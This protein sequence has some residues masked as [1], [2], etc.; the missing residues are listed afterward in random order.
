MADV[1][2]SY[3]RSDRPRCTLIR[4]ALAAL[5]IDVWFDAGI[6]PGHVF[7][8]EIEHQIAESKAVLVL[9]S[10]TSAAS[11]WVRAEARV[12]REA[13]KLAAAFLEPCELPLE[14][15]SVQTEMLAAEGAVE[16]DPVWPGL[17]RR[18][19]ELVGRPGLADFARLAADPATRPEAWRRWIERHPADPLVDSAVERMVEGAVP[20]LRA[21]LATERARRAAA[22]AELADHVE[23]SR[24]QSG[25]LATAARDLAKARR[26]RDEA[27]RARSDADGELAALRD[28]LAQRRGRLPLVSADVGAGIVLDQRLAIYVAVLMWTLSIWFLSSSIGRLSGSR[29]G[30]DDVFWLIIGVIA[31]IVPSALLTIVILIKRRALAAVAAKEAETSPAQEPR[32]LP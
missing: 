20:G 22:E 11:D 16:A 10:Q 30:L 14:F 21:E 32:P 26:E 3:A 28:N 18:I 2:I 6:A 8:R 19:G 5:R 29:G 31:L 12:G 27:A 9:W 15:R 24:A 23:A 17:V 1:F 7:D 4:D 25:E 13:G